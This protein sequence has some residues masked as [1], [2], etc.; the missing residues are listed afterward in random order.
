MDQGSW[1]Q[2]GRWL[3]I[4][5]CESKWLERHVILIPLLPIIGNLQQLAVLKE[6]KFRL[7]RVTTFCIDC[8]VPSLT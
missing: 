6:E 2:R 4:I 8:P 5:A 1:D 7:S 3:A